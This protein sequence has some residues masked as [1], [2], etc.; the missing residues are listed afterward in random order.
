MAR[1]RIRFLGA[2]LRYLQTLRESDAVDKV[3]KP[4]VETVGDDELDRSA[5][6]WPEI[7]MVAIDEFRSAGRVNKPKIIRALNQ[8]RKK[9]L[10]VE[11]RQST[12]Q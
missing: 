5:D 8:I 11:P 7:Q 2:T 4:Y 9:V 12:G 1:N 6:G 3:F 10:L